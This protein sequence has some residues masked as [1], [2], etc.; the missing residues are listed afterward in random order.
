MTCFA[1]P[2]L[3]PPNADLWLTET[4]D[5]SHNSLSGTIPT[6]L[7]DLSELV[8]LYLNDNSLTGGI[9]SALGR[10]DNLGTIELEF[11]HS[12]ATLQPHQLTLQLVTAETMTLDGNII[13][14]SVPAKV[15]A[16]RNVRLHELVTDCAA[17]QCKIPECCTSCRAY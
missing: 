12:L 7:G 9:P 6:K 1:P 3:K 13:Q 15:C 8:E 17:I 14:G 11:Y 5:L 10:L 16:L 2:L 4:L